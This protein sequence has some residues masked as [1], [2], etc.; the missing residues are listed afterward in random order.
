MT[1]FV[2]F[3]LA[4]LA[5][6]STAPARAD[7]SL[8]QVR[9]HLL[10]AST[11]PAPGRSIDLGIAIDP[12]PGWHIYWQNPGE[13]GYAPRFAWTLPAGFRV[14]AIRHPAPQRIVAA[15]STVNV[16]TGPAVLLTS[17]TVPA[18]AHLGDRVHIAAVA[19]LLVCSDSMCV[20]QSVPFARELAVG[21]GTQD[22]ADAPAM[23]QARQ[24][25]PRPWPGSVPYA[26]DGGKLVLNAAL[27][28]AAPG[29]QVTLF[30]TDATLGMPGA[31][32][33]AT[34]FA[35]GSL[36]TGG[37][38]DLVVTYARPGASPSR[39]FAI[40]A[41]PPAAGTG[42]ASLWLAATAIAGALLGGL[43]LN[44]MPC[45]FPILSLKA[46]ALARAG[47]DP[48][49]A[50][51]EALGYLAGAVAVMLGLGAIVLLLRAGGHAAGWAFQ[52]QDPRV[53]A[54]LLLLVVAIATNLAGLF[55][56]PAL[57]LA[58]ARRAGFAGGFGTGALA[59]FVA[60]PCTGPF[61]AGA[62]GVALVLPPVLALP[63]F[64]SLGLGLALPFVAI[65][66]HEP[67]RRLLPRP[68]HWMVT[69]R[70]LLSLPMFV[71]ALGL[72]WLLGRLTG[73]SGMTVGVALAVLGGVALWWAGL[74]QHAGKAAT[75]A[76]LLMA[77][78]TAATLL[79]PAGATGQ[80]AS[81]DAIVQPYSP[82][83]LAALRAAHKPVLVYATADWCLTCKV[84]ESTS[85]SST[86]VRTAFAAAGAVMLE[87]DWTHPD[88]Q[89]TRLLAEHGRAGVPLYV[90]YA[91]D[92]DARVLPQVLTPGLIAALPGER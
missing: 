65:G 87:A 39:A 5:A 74:R 68:G 84:N 26:A 91:R 43:L 36:R 21:A 23:A 25:L 59:A 73:V 56:L 44:L 42:S 16:H 45:V 15:G 90:W 32:E 77:A 8:P 49:E 72:A 53:V 82:D 2:L 1:R 19:D 69:L 79:V 38:L 80:P 47:G 78:A 3:W 60:T 28:A 20:P 13:T 67:A 83:R 48:R 75:P 61:M 7:S 57:P 85:L 86:T 54:V 10:V 55:E 18:S 88:P 33:R 4:L 71:T 58:S 51:A 70:R 17:L 24:R 76:L 41:V 35:R 12:G 27:P 62:L 31:F 50:R 66:F 81:R 9:V 40:H 22:A 37:P 52:I 92:G 89:V 63:V 6:L 30:T 46:M 34:S 14:G 64:A 11:T 29:E